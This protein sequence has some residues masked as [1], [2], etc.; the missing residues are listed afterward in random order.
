MASAR[1]LTRRRPAGLVAEVRSGLSVGEKIAKL[2]EYRRGEWEKLVDAVYKRRGWNSNGV[3][4]IETLKRLGMD[5]PEVVE[6]VR[7]YQ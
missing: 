5:F 6:V 1:R 7:P 4:T 2:L 3:P